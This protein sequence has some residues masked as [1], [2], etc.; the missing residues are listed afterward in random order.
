MLVDS[1]AHL[2]HERFAED[3]DLLL[4]R[5]WNAGVRTILSIGIGDGPSSMDG[6]LQLARAYRDKPGVPRIYATAGVHP[7]EAAQCDTLALANLEALL[8][9][10]EVVGCGEI[11]LDFYHAENP[12]IE[13]QREAFRAQMEIAARRKKLI[14]IHCRPGT[15]FGPDADA[16]DQTLRMLEE[17]WQPTGLGGI[18]HCFSGDKP[19]VERALALGFLI[20]FAGNLTYPSAGSLRA[21]AASIPPDRLL[22]ETD[23]PFLA[24]MPD[25]GKRNEPA[26]VTRTAAVLAEFRGISPEALA[27]QTTAN[28]LRL[29]GLAHT[30]AGQ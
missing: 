28:F 10:P 18:L 20:S 7:Q 16:W 15:A 4:A 6:A 12:A 25:R 22:V 29:F 27:E 26:L 1:H 5:A 8:E 17:H 3:R 13:V 21:L 19:H 30:L 23:C 2:D 11:G 9:E 24:P 14:I